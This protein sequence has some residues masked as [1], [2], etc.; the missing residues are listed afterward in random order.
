[1]Y[2][3][4]KFFL[5]SILRGVFLKNYIEYLSDIKT[6]YKTILKQKKGVLKSVQA[7]IKLKNY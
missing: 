4:L 2:K 1:M 5:F 7:K 6:L 3:K